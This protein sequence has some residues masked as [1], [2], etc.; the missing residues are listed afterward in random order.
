M[1]ISCGK[2]W[3]GSQRRINSLAEETTCS[4]GGSASCAG[5]AGQPTAV[6][7]TTATTSTSTIANAVNPSTLTTSS[8]RLAPS[9]PVKSIT[10]KKGEDTTKLLKYIDDNVIGKNGTFFGPFGRRKV[11]YCDYTASGRS[12]QFLE[13]YIAKEVLP[14][15]GDTRASTSI[16]SLQSSL[17]RHEA[18]DIVRHAVGAGEQD[19][20]LFTGQGTAAALRALLRHLDLSKSTVVFVGPFEHHANLRPWREH[21]VRIIR[22]SETR[23]G[24]LDLNDLDRSLIKMRSEGVT[25]MIGCF[26]AASCIT[27]VL[28]DDVAT[29]LLLHQYGALS[30]WDYT[31]AAPYVQIDM[32]PHLPAS[33]RR[34]CTKT[35]LFS[36]GTSSSAAYSRPECS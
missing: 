30:I 17:F 10:A 26:S 23:E 15:L 8:Q 2:N 5:L 6:V 19:A 31:T 1:K 36:P 12:L 35:R 9:R 33:V 27:G 20:V 32:N 3:S 16:C 29:T 21:G 25:Q 14:Y 22:V 4:T 11:V 7:S 34:P 28:A 13:E 24:F 18:R